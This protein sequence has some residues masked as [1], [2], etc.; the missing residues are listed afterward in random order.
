M[1]ITFHPDGTAE[2][3]GENH[4][5]DGSVASRAKRRASHIEP[6]MPDL[7]VLFH[8]VRW[9]AGFLAGRL[10]QRR[11]LLLLPCLDEQALHQYLTFLWVP[12]P[13]TMFQSIAKLPEGAWLGSIAPPSL[14]PA[15]TKA[16]PCRLRGLARAP[17][18]GV[19]PKRGFRVS[20]HPV[21]DIGARR[22]RG[23]RPTVIGLLMAKSILAKL[24]VSPSS[25]RQALPSGAGAGWKCRLSRTCHR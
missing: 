4:L 12:D 15:L 24:R 13:R 25:T 5:L 19:E 22:S 8:A 14:W 21:R 2:H 1:Q 9:L 6:Y 3:V 11:P 17:N 16:P 23:S 7:R 10:E 20:G 18:K